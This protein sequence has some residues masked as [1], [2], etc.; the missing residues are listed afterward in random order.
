MGKV[1]VSLLPREGGDKDAERATPVASWLLASHWELP[2][3]MTD[4][5]VQVVDSLPAGDF[6]SC[7][8]SGVQGPR[9]CSATGWH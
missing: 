4:Y 5:H 3:S 1:N 7:H 2:I 8:L 6:T 9:Q